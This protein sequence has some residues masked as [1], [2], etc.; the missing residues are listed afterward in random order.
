LT[1]FVKVERRS[2]MR[3]LFAVSM[4]AAALLAAPRLLALEQAPQK[5]VVGVLIEH[6]Q[7]LN[8]TDE[9]E[10]KITDIRK[11]Y[12]PKVQVAAKELA[13]AVKEE[14]E[15]ARSVLTDLQKSQLMAMKEE[16]K[17][18]RAERL[19]ERIVHIDELDLTDGEMVKITAIR[20]EYRPKFAKA[21]ESMHGLLTD[22]QKKARQAALDAGKKRKEV[23]TSLSVTSEV[24]EK[25]EAA[26]KEM[27]TLVHDALE[28]MRDVLGEG[29]QAK[30]QELKA[31]RKEHVRD[32][33]AHAI[34]NFK[35]LNLTSDQMAKL[36]EIR[37]ESGAKV[38][39]AGN[40]LRALVREETQAITAVLKG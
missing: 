35:E 28:K 7:D 2:I 39:E 19:A 32:R 18:M 33:H 17:E 36:A 37:K 11:A 16:R 4:L 22:D 25:I 30:L 27:K 6:I 38:H 40:K 1:W 24:K 12:Q 8:L 31:E 26:G 21:M 20:E 15:K 34:M 29:Q 23:V 13:A 10:A 3:T 9:Q 5:E 14:V